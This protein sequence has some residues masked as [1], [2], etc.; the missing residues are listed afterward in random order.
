MVSV[1]TNQSR[2][3][4]TVA[5]NRLRIIGGIWRGR[6]IDFPDATGLRPTSDRLRETLFNW[7]QGALPGSRCLDLFAGSGVLGFEALSRGA[8]EVVLVEASSYV[9]KYLR[10][11]ATRLGSDRI[12]IMNERADVY[13][14]GRSRVFDIVFLDPPFGEGLLESA[15]HQ[16]VEG[17]W[18]RPG[19]YV[20]I[21][22]ESEKEAL[23]LPSG[24]SIIRS[25]KAGRPTGLLALWKE[26]E[27]TVAQR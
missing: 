25:Q 14:Q 22:Y 15:L 20:Y 6:R 2:K 27:V 3:S 5:R 17:D 16:L 11:N 24:L 1:K 19:A 18:L 26:G 4:K 21:E 13:L 23:V 12:Q 10:G 8:S 9:A 7:L